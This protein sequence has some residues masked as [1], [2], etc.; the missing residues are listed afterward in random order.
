MGASTVTNNSNYCAGTRTVTNRFI[1][2]ALA[3]SYVQ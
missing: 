2:T 1:C 3:C